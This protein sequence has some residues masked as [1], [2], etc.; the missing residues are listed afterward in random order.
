MNNLGLSLKKFFTNKNTVTIIGVVAILVILYFM[1][2]NQIKKATL[3][4][5]VPVAKETIYPQT[6][7][8]ST[9]VT[10]IKVAQAAKPK[11]VIMSDQ[12]IIDHYTGV[13]VTVPKGSMFYKEF[14]VTK[15]DLPGSWLKNLKPQSV[16]SLELER[17]YSFPVNVA[18]TFGNSIQPG[19]Y[20]DFYLKAYDNNKG[21][22]FG[23]IY[24]NVEVLSVTDSS[25]KE[26][27]K[28]QN[29]IGTPAYLNFGFDNDTYQ[30]FKFVEYASGD[31][32][33]VVVPRGGD[34]LSNEDKEKI[35]TSHISAGAARDYVRLKGSKAYEKIWK[36][37][38]PEEDLPTNTENQA[39]TENTNQN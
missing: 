12:A 29:A 35:S 24:D 21:I 18:T 33:L 19:D 23:R 5:E 10:K 17:P 16:N 6:K 1:Y 11:D 30:I 36:E 14:I 27:F 22:I 7:I 9:M 3:E 20:V 39:N 31:L 15:E 28:S 37:G 2:T 8:Q 26:V 25:G 13:G 4:I 38:Y 34:P 32:S